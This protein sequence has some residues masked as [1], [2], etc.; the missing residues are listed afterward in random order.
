VRSVPIVRCL[1]RELCPP[2]YMPGG[3]GPSWLQCRSPSSDYMI[4]ILLELHGRNPS[5][6]RSSPFL[7]G[8]RGTIYRQA[9]EHC[10][11]K[12]WKP[13]LVPSGLAE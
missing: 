12:L 1:S 10:M 4:V 9:P 5:Q 8:T 11:V 6:T 3:K 13:L 2:L 7:T